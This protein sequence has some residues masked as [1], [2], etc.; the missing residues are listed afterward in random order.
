MKG[1][2]KKRGNLYLGNNEIASNH[3]I[4]KKKNIKS[5][6]TIGIGECTVDYDN[7]PVSHH[8][9]IMLKENE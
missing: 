8:L 1:K 9:K 2:F 4:L 7:T 5:V 6:I 3:S